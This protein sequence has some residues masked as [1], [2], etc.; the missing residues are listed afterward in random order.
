MLLGTVKKMRGVH[1][2]DCGHIAGNIVGVNIGRR[3]SKVH[4]F[5][6]HTTQHKCIVQIISIAKGRQEIIETRPLVMAC[7]AQTI[8]SRR[9][10]LGCD[11]EKEHIR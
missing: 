1:T 5:H 10:N 8:I 7:P 2:K 9:S 11:V 6:G 4:F 3:V